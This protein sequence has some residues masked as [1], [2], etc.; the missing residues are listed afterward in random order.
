MAIQLSPGI[1]IIDNFFS[2]KEC[3][4]WIAFSEDHTYQTATIGTGRVQQ[5]R[6][7]VRN[8]DRII[9][10]DESLAE[11]LYHRAKEH[12]VSKFGKMSLHGLNSRFRFYRYA[13]GQQFKPHQDGSYIKD[14]STW[15]EFAF[16]IY[17]NDDYVGGQTKF[18]RAT[19][20]PKRGMALLF[21]HQLVHEGCP[22]IEGTK[23]VLRTDVMY[24]FQESEE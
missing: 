15:S 19:V 8:N 17:L 11:S 23:Y 21:K 3:Q 20:E 24:K 9:Y 16:L 14:K 18:I 12:M 13:L 2:D 22:V 1:W 7:G 4:D 10:D 6:L 5:V